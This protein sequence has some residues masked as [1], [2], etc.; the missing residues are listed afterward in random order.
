MESAGVFALVLEC[1]PAELGRQI[2]EAVD[3]PTIGI[4]AG[5]HCSGQVQ[6]VNDLLG[7]FTDF[8]PKHS[9]RYANLAEEIRRA[10]SE[11]VSDVREGKFP[12]PE[13]SF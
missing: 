3:V 7:L 8:Q 9:K 11:Y 4:G 12:G 13:N 1:M 10:F 5:V 6:V 2:T